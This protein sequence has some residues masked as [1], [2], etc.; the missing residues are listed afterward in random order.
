MSEGA[1]RPSIKD[2]AALAGVSSKTVSNVLHGQIR[3]AEDTHARVTRAIAELNYQPNLHARKLRSGRSGILAVAVPNVDL[4][5]FAELTSQLVRAAYAQGCTVLLDETGG[6]ASREQSLLTGTAARTADGVIFSPQGVSRDELVDILSESGKPVVLLG[7]H[8]LGLPVDHVMI[9]NVAAGADATRHLL[10]L[11]RRRIAVIGTPPGYD[12][13]QE[14]AE[15]RLRG[16]RNALQAAGAAYDP[17]LVMSAGARRPADGAAAMTALLEHKP[18]AVFCL[19]D[20]LALGAIRALHS[21]GLH[22]PDDVAVVGVDNIGQTQYSVPTVTTVAPDKAA[23]AET[24]VKLLLRRVRDP[25]R[26]P[27][28]IVTPHELVVRESTTLMH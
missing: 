7:E 18:D 9:D 12:D 5:Y 19:T 23:L 17:R 15:L 6:S 2:V 4:P 24:A 10:G 14:H 27:H 8:V 25:G 28:Q 13:D 20:L 11:G 16:Y 3:V 22:V 26:E 1:R 21:H